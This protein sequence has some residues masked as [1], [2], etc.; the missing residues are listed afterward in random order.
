MSRVFISSVFS[1][2]SYLQW[3]SSPSVQ[4]S[5]FTRLL[6]F[7][8]K[9]PLLP[10]ESSF[11]RFC[12]HAWLGSF[13]FYSCN[14]ELTLLFE[15]TLDLITAH[16]AFITWSSPTPRS[17]PYHRP[18]TFTLPKISI[19]LGLSLLLIIHSSPD[20]RP[21]VTRSSPARHP[22]VARSSPYHRPITFTLPKILNFLDHF[23]RCLN[24]Y[25]NFE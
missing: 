15:T 21:L 24:A 11:S 6:D 10:P 7:F 25:L 13:Y 4:L 8:Y 18:I 3:P 20:R 16:H 14:N 2:P 9:S 5:F 23:K 19:F 17:S 1:F 22:L 12:A